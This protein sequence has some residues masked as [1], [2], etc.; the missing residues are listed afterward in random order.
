M[1][2]KIDRSLYALRR[3]AILGTY[4]GE[5]SVHAAVALFV[6]GSTALLLRLMAGLPAN[7]AALALLVVLVTPLTAYL[8]SRG[9]FLSPEAAAAWLDVRAGATGMLVTELELNDPRWEG[10][11]EKVLA[12]APAL[13]NVRLRPVATRSFM[14]V[15]F[16]ALALWIDIPKVTIGV[17]PNLY[18]ASVEDLREKLEALE[19]EI[20]FEEE[21]SA[22]LAEQLERL[23][24]ESEQALNPEATFEAIDQM[25]ERLKEEALSAQE[26]AE[27][28]NEALADATEAMEQ[29]LGEGQELLEGA[30][31]RLTEQGLDKN[32]PSSLLEKLGAGLELPEGTELYLGDLQNLSEELKKAL[33]G[34]MG[35]FI[36]AGLLKPGKLGELGELGDLSEY[37]FNDHECDENCEKPGGK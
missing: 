10:R 21:E 18:E 13:P 19:E 29:D 20:E 16:V 8:R 2:A 27:Q 17:P 26:A 5:W 11:A 35:K 6:G 30:M 4:L 22:E 37:K 14:G 1:P 25:A 3:K 33:E 34:K 28:A 9:R 32:L 15:A 31:A 23:E 7:Q 12:T 36:D 24:E